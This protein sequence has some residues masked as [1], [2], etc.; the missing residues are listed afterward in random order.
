MPALPNHSFGLGA[1]SGFALETSASPPSS[2][3]AKGGLTRSATLPELLSHPRT[4]RTPQR[5]GKE[6]HTESDALFRVALEVCG[7]GDVET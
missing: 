6:S 2:F 1:R 4:G 3:E 7:G 5:R